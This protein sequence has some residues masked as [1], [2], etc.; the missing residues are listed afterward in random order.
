MFEQSVA[1]RLGA[2]VLPSGAS[3]PLWLTIA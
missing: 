3:I 2:I 1:F